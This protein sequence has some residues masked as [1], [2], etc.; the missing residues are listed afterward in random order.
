MVG[1]DANREALPPVL[2][3]NLCNLLLD[4][5]GDDF[6]SLRTEAAR[7]LARLDP[8]YSVGYVA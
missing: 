1:T 5:F 8:V 6:L 4:R 7:I 2:K 3:G